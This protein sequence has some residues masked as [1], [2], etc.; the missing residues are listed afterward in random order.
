MNPWIWATGALVIALGELHA[1]GYYLIWI[2][3]GAAV[4][5]AIGLAV[6]LTLEAQIGVFVPASLLSCIAGYF[7]YRKLVTARG[8]AAPVNQRAL[9]MV[10]TTG[11]AAETFHNGHGKV[12]LADSVWLAEGPDLPKGAAVVVVALRGTVVIVES[13]AH[14]KDIADS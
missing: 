9:D 3:V 10:G 14:H 11:V 2:A 13:A 12:R 4:T 5:A 7:V 6:D 8:D 1:P